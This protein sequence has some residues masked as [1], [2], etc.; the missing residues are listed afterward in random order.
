MAAGD[1]Q[2]VW[3]PEMV[4]ELRRRWS[5]SLAWDEVVLLCEDAMALRTRIRQE[6]GILPPRMR[7]PKCGAV[8]RSDIAGISVRS[9]LFALKKD[10]Q[11]DETEFAR[12]DLSWKKHRTVH[13]LDA[14]GRGRQEP[15]VGCAEHS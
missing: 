15:D 6:R 10:G 7:C 9:L 12:L 5:T 11:I 2:R 3:F 14:Y 13:R 1:A 8:S 4:D